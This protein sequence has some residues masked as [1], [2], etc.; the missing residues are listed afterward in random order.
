MTATDRHP[1]E[2][3]V[4]F[5]PTPYPPPRP[6][7]RRCSARLALWLHL[8]ACLVVWPAVYATVVIATFVGIVIVY[9]DH[10]GPLFWPLAWIAS[11]TAYGLVVGI[12]LAICGRRR[13]WYLRLIPVVIA[14]V[15]FVWLGILGA[16]G[17]IPVTTEIVLWAIP[18]TATVALSILI[19]SAR[20]WRPRREVRGETGA[21]GPASA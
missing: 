21:P 17:T 16:L 14:A 6:L 10:G 11:A 5:H 13:R 18:S 3:P 12:P 15:P 2:P 9:N 20:W 1:G 8:A 19:Q 7:A 4:Q